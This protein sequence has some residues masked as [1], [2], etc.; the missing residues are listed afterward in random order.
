MKKNYKNYILL[1]SRTF[2]LFFSVLLVGL[3]FTT[4]M[5][6]SL[7]TFQNAQGITPQVLA[8]TANVD[9]FGIKMLYPTKSGGEQWF[10]NM[11]NPTSDPRFNP[12]F[13]IVQ[14]GDGSWKMRSNKVRMNVYTSTGYD[15]SK[16]ATYDER[17]LV[18]KVTCKHQMI[19]EM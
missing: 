10:M 9:K 2:S 13:S 12:Q 3:I 4:A 14:N 5:L 7:S 6:S 8:P 16:I 19:G 1:K 18:Q 11:Q 15:E 17:Q